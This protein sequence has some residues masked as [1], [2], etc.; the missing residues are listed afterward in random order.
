MVAV[1]AV[2]VVALL[3]LAT[4]NVR[5]EKRRWISPGAATAIVAWVI[6][7][8]AF[9]VYVSKFS[10]Y[11]AT[12]GALAGFV[13]F[14]LALWIGNLALLFG[15]EFDAEIERGRELEQGRPAENEI[16]LPPRDTRVAEKDDLRERALVDEARDIRTAADRDGRQTAGHS[17]E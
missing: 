8:G 4:P 16:L 5:H 9:G 3:Y 12:Y 14:L 10:S 17:P 7:T 13:V 6:A 11:D 15:A 2:L 1:L